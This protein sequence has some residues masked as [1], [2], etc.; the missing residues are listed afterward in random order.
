MYPAILVLHR[1]RRIDGKLRLVIDDLR[2]FGSFKAPKSF[3]VSQL[4]L[5]LPCPSPVLMRHRPDPDALE[6]ERFADDPIRSSREL[7]QAR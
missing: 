4:R 2:E 1:S 7:L 6:L 5:P 3:H